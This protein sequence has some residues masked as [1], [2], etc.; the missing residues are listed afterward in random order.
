MRRELSECWGCWKSTEEG[1]LP[2]ARE[3]TGFL[4]V[5]SELYLVRSGRV[6]QEETEEEEQNQANSKMTNV[7]KTLETAEI[8]SEHG[9][10]MT[11]EQ[12]QEHHLHWNKREN[13]YGCIQD[14]K[15]DRKLRKLKMIH[16]LRHH[17]GG[18][19]VVRRAQEV[20]NETEWDWRIEKAVISFIQQINLLCLGL[21]PFYRWP[22]WLREV[23]ISPRVTHR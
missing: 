16:A 5:T 22:N 1:H 23:K 17:K 20:G 13:I 7:V 19:F 18:I 15:Q 11:A 8:N 9:Q 14:E 2:E 21:V 10:K 12:E 6:H 4:Q 3:L